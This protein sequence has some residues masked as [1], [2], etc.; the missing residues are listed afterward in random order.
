MA[1]DW[2][3]DYPIKSHKKLDVRYFPKSSVARNYHGWDFLFDC[4][5]FSEPCRSRNRYF[6][7]IEFSFNQSYH[8]L[9]D[10]HLIRILRISG[11]WQKPP[12]SHPHESSS[13]WRHQYMTHPGKWLIVS[14]YLIDLR[15]SWSANHISPGIYLTSDWSEFYL[16]DSDWSNF[17]RPIPIGQNWFTWWLYYCNSFKHWF[18]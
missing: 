16:I 1:S 6:R 7:I 12:V 15:V 14:Q 4:P 17:I 9:I 10:V 3:N 11:T 8:L 5:N 18:E 13:I 2:L